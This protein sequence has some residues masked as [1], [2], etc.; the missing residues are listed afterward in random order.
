M[1]GIQKSRCREINLHCHLETTC[2]LVMSH[3]VHHSLPYICR[4]S[5]AYS[6]INNSLPRYLGDMDICL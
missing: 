1:I 3:G 2:L 4:A 5:S 6:I